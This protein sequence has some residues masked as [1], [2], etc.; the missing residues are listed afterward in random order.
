MLLNTNRSNSKLEKIA[1]LPY[2][3]PRGMRRRTGAMMV[4]IALTLVI[5]F[6]GAA[7][8]ID[9]AYMHLVRAELRTA[10]D[11]AARAGAESLA[12]TQQQNQ[13]VNTALALAERNLVAGNGLTLSPAD[14]T[15]GSVRSNGGAGRFQFVANRP[16]FTA[17]EVNG[18]RDSASADGSV[19]L[20]FARV[21][22]ADA[23]EPTE[24]SVSAASVRDVALV[25]D[26]SGS[27]FGGRLRDLKRAV[28][29]FL[30]EVQ[31]VSPTT[32]VSLSVYATRAVKVIDLTPN[33]GAVRGAVNT[34]TARGFTAIG[35]GLLMGSDSL[36]NDRLTRRFADKTVIVM[37]D[38]N[39]N[40][41]PSPATTVQTAVN[42]EQTVH[43]ITFGGGA[44]QGLMRDVAQRTE[45]G[46]HVHAD[47]GA[48]LAEAFREIARSLAVILID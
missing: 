45:G 37:T 47:D 15:L 4:L 16:P 17:V 24:S 33:F 18:R 35:E 27:M 34:L 36:V 21:F 2:R 13:A 11:A 30:D 8:S 46:I 7:F 28:N 41:G 25:L 22:S 43:T 40:R 48:D 12:R 31:V 10:T 9:V 39:H 38:G 1:M 29:I 5:L 32:Q 20:F 23:F 14:I 42:R 6:V 19:G 44:N 3:R 26:V